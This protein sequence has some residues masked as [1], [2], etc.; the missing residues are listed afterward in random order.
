MRAEAGFFV[1]VYFF[2]TGLFLFTELN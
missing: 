2:P 1:T